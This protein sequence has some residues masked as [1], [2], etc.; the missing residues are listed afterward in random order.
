MTRSPELV[1]IARQRRVLLGDL[2]RRAADL[3]VRA[4]ALVVA[5]QRIRP[6]AV[7]IIVVVIV[8][9]AATA[10]AIVATAHA[11]VL[12]L[13]PHP[14]LFIFE[15]SCTDGGASGSLPFR[16]FPTVFARSLLRRRHE[17]SCPVSCYYP[18]E[19]QYEA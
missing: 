12:L 16:V 5:G 3:H 17:P 13:W 8:I 1:R 15:K 4:V 18:D 6:L 14:T 2:L 11:P 9:V 19:P 10:A 7:V